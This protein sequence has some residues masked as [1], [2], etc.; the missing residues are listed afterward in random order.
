ME[1]QM[2]IYERVG[3]HVYHM[4]H[5]GGGLL[6]YVAFVYMQRFVLSEEIGKGGTHRAWLWG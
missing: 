6:A 4:L 1:R 5:D 2:Y 3:W